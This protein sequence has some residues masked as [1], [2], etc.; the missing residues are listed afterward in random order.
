MIVTKKIEISPEEIVDLIKEKLND[1]EAV[2]SF[3]IN[4]ETRRAGSTDGVNNYRE[5]SVFNGAKV[6]YK[7]EQDLNESTRDK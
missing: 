6:E 7:Y 1:S 2:I 5:V 4:T 3:V